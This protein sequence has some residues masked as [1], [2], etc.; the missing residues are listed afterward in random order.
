[1]S[2]A[3][4]PAASG[5]PAASDPPDGLIEA[6]DIFLSFG[7]TPALRSAS[8]SVAADEILAV[9]GPSGSGKST[10]CPRPF[11]VSMKVTFRMAMWRHGRPRRVRCRA[12]P[13]TS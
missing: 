2:A 12:G 10:L 11:R 1:M 3:R 13:F 8:M 7:Q 4:V 6:R 5:I 9:M